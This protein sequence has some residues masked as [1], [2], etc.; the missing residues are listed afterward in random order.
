VRLA[1]AIIDELLGLGHPDVYRSLVDD[2]VD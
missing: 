2:N 1:E